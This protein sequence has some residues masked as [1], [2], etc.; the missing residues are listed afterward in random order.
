MNMSR[1]RATRNGWARRCFGSARRA[2]PRPGAARV[3]VAVDDDFL[4]RHP[5]RSVSQGNS[6]PDGG[7]KTAR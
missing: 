6:P 4:M 2:L 1:F 7:P 5:N 3:I